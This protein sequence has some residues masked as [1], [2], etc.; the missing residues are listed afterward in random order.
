L[1]INRLTFSGSGVRAIQALLYPRF[2][3]IHYPFIGYCWY[4][5]DKLGPFFLIP[6]AVPYSLFFRVIF[7]RI[8]ALCTDVIEH[9]KCC[10]IS[11]KYASGCDA[12][13]DLNSSGDNL[14][15]CL[16]RILG[17]SDSFAFIRRFHSFIVVSPIP[18]SFA[19]AS[20]V[21]PFDTCANT[22][23]LNLLSYAIC[24]F[25]HSFGLF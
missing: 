15:G 14:F 24:L 13:K 8:K 12:T 7:R 6:L 10:A 20:C 16:W 1:S 9:L 11:D 17:S 3:N 2:V 5:V 18:N 22:R 4:F 23:S 19:V 21:W 25:Y